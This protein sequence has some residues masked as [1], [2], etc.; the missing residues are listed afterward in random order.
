[1]SPASGLHIGYHR[2]RQPAP[3]PVVVSI[4]DEVERLIDRLIVDV[5]ELREGPCPANPTGG[6]V[7]AASC[8]FVVCVYCDRPFW[9]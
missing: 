3:P 6:H 7:A 1:M 8:G 5:H 9:R 4:D 2:V